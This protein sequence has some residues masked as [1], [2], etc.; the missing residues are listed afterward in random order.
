M[1]NL[2]FLLLLAIA[3]Q[4]ALADEVGAPNPKIVNSALSNPQLEI[5][6]AEQGASISSANTPTEVQASVD[7]SAE[8]DSF[9][10]AKSEQINDELEE[11]LA[12][13]FVLPRYY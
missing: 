10:E 12:Q 7:K 9:V 1:K 13:H 5:A 6:I 2:G 3:S 4:G 11:R 8:L